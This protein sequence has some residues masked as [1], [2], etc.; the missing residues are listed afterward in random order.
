MS[1]GHTV[2]VAACRAQTDD[3]SLPILGP[4]EEHHETTAASTGN[5]AR[6]RAMSGC[7]RMKL[8]NADTPLVCCTIISCEFRD[9]PV[10]QMTMDDTI[11]SIAPGTRR[12]PRRIDLDVRP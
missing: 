3:Q 11:S 9:W 1:K 7:N 2:S 6:K 4:H 12:M 10:K 5:L 8:I